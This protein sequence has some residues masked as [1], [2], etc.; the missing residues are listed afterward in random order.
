MLTKL[1]VEIGKFTG[2]YDAVQ[3][4]SL[5]QQAVPGFKK[6]AGE[7]SL[8]DPWRP[9]APN[10]WWY[11][12]KEKPKLI[13]TSVKDAKTGAI[14]DTGNRRGLDR[15]WTDSTNLAWLGVGGRYIS[16]N[17]ETFYAS[18]HGALPKTFPV[19]PAPKDPPQAEYSE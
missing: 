13:S 15:F 1:T 10:E 3:L 19:T 5:L 8:A 4:L 7:G 2:S 11:C 6:P 17:P 18:S 9:K 12:A 14:K 16:V